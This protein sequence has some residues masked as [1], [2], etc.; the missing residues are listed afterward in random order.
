M[1]ARLAAGRTRRN[2]IL[3]K[4]TPGRHILTFFSK[5]DPYTK[6]KQTKGLWQYKDKNKKVWTFP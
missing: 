3:W 4:K 2:Y 1:Q 6:M 5:P